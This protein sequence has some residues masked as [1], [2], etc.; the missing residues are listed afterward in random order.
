MTSLAQKTK[1]I[2]NRK[3]KPNKENQRKDMKRI[4]NNNAILSRLAAADEASKKE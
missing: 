2:R 3:K 4:Q 1:R